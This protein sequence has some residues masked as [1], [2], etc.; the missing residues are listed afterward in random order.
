MA[1]LWLLSLLLP[2]FGALLV[3]PLCRYATLSAGIAAVTTVLAA[4]PGIYVSFSLLG[5][6]PPVS[7]AYAWSLPGGALQIDVDAVSAFFLLP[8]FILSPLCA[9]YGGAYLHQ[10]K[11][12]LLGFHWAFFLLLVASMILVLSAGQVFLF[13]VAWE[14]M[15]LTSFFLV[16]FDQQEREVRQAAWVYLVASHIGVTLLLGFF[17]YSSQ[18][19]GSLLF[20]DFQALKSISPSLATGLFL[21]AVTGFGIKAGL[22]P[23]HVWLPEAHPAAPS[24]VSALMSAVM[25]NL[26]IYGILRVVTWL[27]QAPAWWG[28]L[29]AGFGIAGALYGIALAAVQ[30]D[31][32]RCLAYST[33]ENVGIIFVGLGVGIYAGAAG[34]PG[35]A[36]LAFAGALLHL[37]NHSLFKGMLFLG[38]GNLV[39]ATATRNMNQLGGLMK[40]LPATSLLLIGGSVAITALPPFNGFIS[41]WLIYLGLLH[42]GLEMPRAMGLPLLLLVSLLALVGA[43]AILVFVRL[44]G[45]SVLG[46]PRSA[47][48]ASAH[49]GSILLLAP[50]AILLAGCVLI[51]LNPLPVLD[52]LR[53]PVVLLIKTELLPVLTLTAFTGLG[54]GVWLLLALIVGMALLLFVQRYRHP[55]VVAATWGCGFALPNNRMSY[56]ATAFSELAHNHLLPRTLRPEVVAAPVT[57]FFPQAAQ[58]SQQSSD[59]VLN[60]LLQLFFTRI[61]NLCQ[62]L[63][64][65][66]QGRL[67]IYLLYIFLTCIGLMIW[68]LWVFGGG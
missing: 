58:L 22:F 20:S 47:A 62:R 31:I 41:E 64:W 39:H 12:K 61:A 36:L 66:Q 2:V 49:E 48:A 23:L 35:V 37:W 60:R 4:I 46:N 25:V 11:G 8:V 54:R 5:G 57:T 18:W 50:P 45:I 34:F 33:V 43:A 13:L 21:L 65:F 17:L 6:H 30:Q 68:S 55:A 32:K 19:S 53:A 44:V 1:G 42:G 14:L 24:H 7:I 26:G 38:A 9:I 56:N 10:V 52:L 67:P 3:V 15:S 29:L 51:G 63:R 59:P 16:A 40:R 27:P 28:L